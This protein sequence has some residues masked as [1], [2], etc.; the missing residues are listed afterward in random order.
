MACLQ[1]ARS[2][3]V[4]TFRRFP[5]HRFVMGPF[6]VSCRLGGDSNGIPLFDI[7]VILLENSINFCNFWFSLL[8]LSYYHISKL[9]LIAIQLY[10][11][12]RCQYFPT[13]MLPEK[14]YC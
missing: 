3:L 4:P 10:N 12:I 1:L 6:H 11:L 13:Y 2:G 7:L 9:L 14:K 8:L 5:R